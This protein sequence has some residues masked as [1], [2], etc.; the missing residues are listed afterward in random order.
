MDAGAVQKVACCTA[1]LRFCAFGQTSRP[2]SCRNKPPVPPY[3]IAVLVLL[4]AYLLGS[5]SGGVLLGRFRGVDIREQGSGFAG[6]ANALRT[7]GFGFALGVVA[8]DT[9]KGVLAA[10]L[11]RQFGSPDGPFDVATL[12][13]GCVLAAMLG[14]VWPVWH[15]FRGG[16]G[17]ATLVGG[18]LIM[19]P[20][21]LPGVLAV[22]LAIL[23]SS[24]YAGLAMV[25][26]GASLPLFALW[27]G[28]GLPRWLFAIAAA[29][30]LLYTYRDNLRRILAGGEARMERA[31][32]LHRIWRGGRR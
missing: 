4:A 29:L 21:V 3:S 22:W 23:L 15:G 32:V 17:A 13:Y 28:A 18:L 26:A 10:W 30:F 25:L 8:I 31:R 9:G 2:S 12:G 24:G 16:K 5:I 11:G 7:Q 1:T 6:G 20:W 14:H 19:W 27:S